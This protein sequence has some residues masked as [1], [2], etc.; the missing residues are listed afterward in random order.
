MSGWAQ[1][2]LSDEFFES[3]LASAGHPCVLLLQHLPCGG[4]QW[5]ELCVVSLS[6]LTD[7]GIPGGK[8]NFSVPFIPIQ[9]QKNG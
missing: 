9:A 2:G 7:L 5:G 1:L 8:E 3:L 6:L 4:A